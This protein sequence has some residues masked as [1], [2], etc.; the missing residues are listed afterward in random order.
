VP[1]DDRRQWYRYHHLFADVLQAHLLDEQ[2]DAAPDLHRRASE[3][4]QQNGEPSEAIRR[5][6]AAR[7]FPRAA[8]L[9]SRQQEREN[10]R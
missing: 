6:L 10:P 8:D 4:Y 2:P 1:L 7:D 9:G 5:A 3:W